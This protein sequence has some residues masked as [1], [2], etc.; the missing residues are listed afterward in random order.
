MMNMD[1]EQNPYDTPPP[2]PQ[3]RPQ[4]GTEPSSSISLNSYDVAGGY[5]QSTCAAAPWSF[6]NDPYPRRRR[7][8]TSLPTNS[9]GHSGFKDVPVKV[10]V[11]RPDKD[12]W[13]YVGRAVVSQEAFGQGSRIGAHYNHNISIPRANVTPLRSVVRAVGSRKVMTAFSEVCCSSLSRVIQVSQM[14]VSRAHQSRRKN[15]ATS[16]LLVARR[17]VVWYRGH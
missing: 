16:S 6:T 3:M 5:S 15:V 2:Q 4:L 12:N 10:H 9:E 1:F 8:A 17:V 14:V 11:R 7:V 13:Q